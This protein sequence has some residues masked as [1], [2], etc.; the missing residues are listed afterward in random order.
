MT[1]QQ[2]AERPVLR[3]VRGDPTPEELAAV[4]A[5]LTARRVETPAS[6]PRP[7]GGWADRTAGL[8]RVLAAGA[9]SWR[10]VGRSPGTRTRAG[11]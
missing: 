9:G 5:V 4:I 3:V 1:E 6:P 2:A 8:R 10:A 7:A 11:T